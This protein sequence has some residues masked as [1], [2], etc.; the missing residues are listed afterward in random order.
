VGNRTEASERAAAWLKR[1]RVL[2]EA[3]QRAAF[4]QEELFA[5]SPEQAVETLA[6]LFEAAASRTPAA[7][8]ALHAVAEALGARTLD[9]DWT[10][11]AYALADRGEHLQVKALLAPVRAR[12]EPDPNQLRPDPVLSEMTLGMRRQ[13]ARGHN[14][15]LLDRL[16]LDPDPGVVARVLANPRTTEADVVRIAAR[17]PASAAVLTEVFRHTRW[18]TRQRV[19]TALVRNPY[20]PSEIS[21]RL[22]PQLL[23]RDLREIA[24]DGTLHPALCEE[25]R[26]LVGERE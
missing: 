22:L 18:S 19:R 7:R 8:K 25:A 13:V 15:D 11:A 26:R 5:L 24:V 6:A 16:A 21:M 20:T 4:I 12:R 9:Y 23:L 14:R 10:A 1:C 2:S 17:R 3:I